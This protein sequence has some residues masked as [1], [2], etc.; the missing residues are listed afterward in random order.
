MGKEEVL[1]LLGTEDSMEAGSAISFVL[2]V[3][4]DDARFQQRFPGHKAALG[5]W[6]REKE[7]SE[8]K[9]LIQI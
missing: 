4:D 9:F 3:P 8:G 7:V 1:K 6:L 2:N 5:F